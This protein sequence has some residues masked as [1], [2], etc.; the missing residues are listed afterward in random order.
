MFFWSD[1]IQGSLNQDSVY[2]IQ[3][4]LGPLAKKD[5]GVPKHRT[6]AKLW[7]GGCHG[8]ADHLA[9]PEDSW[10]ANLKATRIDKAW[11]RNPAVQMVRPDASR[12]RSCS[13]SSEHLS[14][15]HHSTSLKTAERPHCYGSRSCVHSAFFLLPRSQKAT[16]VSRLTVHSLPRSD[17]S[18]VGGKLFQ[19]LGLFSPFLPSHFPPFL[20]VSASSSGRC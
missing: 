2:I 13:L 16:S 11:H 15:I 12:Q 4:T 3:F 20:W 8:F 5:V 9:S 19:R 7:T 18:E 1:K 14:L 6:L 10:P 17:R